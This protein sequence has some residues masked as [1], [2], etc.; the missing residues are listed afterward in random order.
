MTCLSYVVGLWDGRK[1]EVQ[2][3]F[4]G[5]CI[6]DVFKTAGRIIVQLLFDFFVKSFVRDHVV[7][8]YNRTDTSMAWKNFLLFYQ[9]LDFHK[10]DD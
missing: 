4:I 10:V 5:C 1:V 2:V 8:P 9:I 7:Q 6:Q 3:L